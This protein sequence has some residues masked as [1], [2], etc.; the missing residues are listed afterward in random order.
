[1]LRLGGST[2]NTLTGEISW[3]TLLS[4]LR[5]KFWNL[6]LSMVPYLRDTRR[7][8]GIGGYVLTS[9]EMSSP[10]DGNEHH[11]YITWVDSFGFSF[12]WNL[13]WSI[14]LQLIVWSADWRLN[15]LLF[16]TQVFWSCWLGWLSLLWYPWY[17][18]MYSSL[19]ANFCW[20]NIIQP[21]LTLAF[22]S[23]SGS[24]LSP[25]SCTH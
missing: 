7:A 14:P 2:T 8:V 3:K 9:K 1:M 21:T 12:T 20:S 10:S 6:G 18:R 15:T 11:Q 13:H 16:R 22:I 24:I 19:K 5:L 25:I 17:S 4:I 23:H